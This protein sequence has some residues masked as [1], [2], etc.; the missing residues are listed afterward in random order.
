[1]LYLPQFT[2]FQVDTRASSTG[3]KRKLFGGANGN[4]FTT[5][6][7]TI[8]KGIRS[9]AAITVSD[10]ENL[11]NVTSKLSVKKVTQD[12]VIVS[13]QIRYLLLIFPELK[14]YVK[15]D[16]NQDTFAFEKPLKK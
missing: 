6:A 9:F 3:Q 7:L 15:P 14:R 12:F 4:S 1:M 16:E 8:P 2:V 5:D 13:G 10:D 11:P